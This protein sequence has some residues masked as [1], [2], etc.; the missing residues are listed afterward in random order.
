MHVHGTRPTQAFYRSFPTTLFMNIPYG[1]VMVAA[2]E[3]LK[4]LMRPSGDYDTRTFL[5][6]GSG[7]GAIAAVATNPLDVV[8]TRLQTQAL[9]TSD[10]MAA[11]AS[12]PGEGSWGRGGKGFHLK[13]AGGG[14]SV[15]AAIHSRAARCPTGRCMGERPVVT[16]QYQGLVDAVSSC[17]P[18]YSPSEVVS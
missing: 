10:G 1:C 13:R 9:K 18:I 2:N 6:A 17:W 11:A 15:A 14:T 16:L 4:R 3:S 5:L 7:A 12:G 8:K